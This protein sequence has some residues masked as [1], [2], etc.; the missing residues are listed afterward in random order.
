MG[1][2]CVLVLVCFACRGWFNAG[3]TLGVWFLTMVPV[4]AFTMTATIVTMNAAMD[5]KKHR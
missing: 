4:S 3:L 1:N 2:L 5:Q